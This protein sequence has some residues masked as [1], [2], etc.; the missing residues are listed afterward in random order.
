[1]FSSSGRQLTRSQGCHWGP[2]GGSLEDWQSALRTRL[3]LM[4]VDKLNSRSRTT[5]STRHRPI[6]Q[7]SRRLQVTPITTLRY[8][9]ICLGTLRAVHQ[10]GAVERNLL[11]GPLLH[12][13]RTVLHSRRRLGN[14]QGH[15]SPMKNRHA[16]KCVQV[17]QPLRPLSHLEPSLVGTA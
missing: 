2:A 12:H 8:L 13:C 7:T 17:E 11:P 9:M 15:S 10:S 14:L 5:L 4:L 3:N 6:Y 16:L 1:M